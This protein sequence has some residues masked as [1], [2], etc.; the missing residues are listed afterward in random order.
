MI[1]LTA[2]MPWFDAEGHLRATSR[3]WGLG[4]GLEALLDRVVGLSLLRE[5]AEFFQAFAP[6]YEGFRERAVKVKALLR[7]PRT[8]FVVVSGPGEDA[9]VS[10]E[11]ANDHV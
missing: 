6:L 3:L 9:I 5:M 11:L 2:L 7:S 1:S 4:R 8:L 10:L